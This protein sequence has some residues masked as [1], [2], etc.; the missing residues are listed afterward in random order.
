MKTIIYFTYLTTI[1]FYGA[2]SVVRDK[3]LTNKNLLD[4]A[5]KNT[6]M[7]PN[8]KEAI[9]SELGI[10]ENSIIPSSGQPEFSNVNSFTR[11]NR[12]SKNTTSNN[13]K[14][15]QN[16]PGFIYLGQF[17]THYYYLSQTMEDWN[18][19]STECTKL[20][21]YLVSIGS[22]E[23][24]SFILNKVGASIQSVHI[25]LYSRG[26][27]WKWINGDAV[28]FQRWASGEPNG[29]ATGVAHLL[30]KADPVYS[31]QGY[32]NDTAPTESHYF[33]LETEEQIP[34]QSS[35]ISG[36]NFLGQFKGHNYYLSQTMEDWNSASTECTKLG[37]YLVSI[38]SNEENSFILNKVGASIQSVHIGLYSRGGY[39]KWINGDAVAFQRWASGE[40]NGGATGVAHLLCK[41]DPVYSRQG[42]WNDTAPTES[43]YFVLET[44]E[45][46]PEQSS[47]ISGFNFLGQF[48]GHNYYLSQTMEDWNSASTECTKLGGYLVSIRSNEENSFILNKVGASIQ[49]VH[50]GLYSRGGYWKWINGDAVAFQ[51]WASGEPNGGATG[52]AH[53]LCKADPVYSR[54]GYWNDTAPTESHYFVLEKD[55]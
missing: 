12:G 15:I 19:A 34:E 27:Y 44:E 29:G 17:G 24:N 48:K 55:Y 32:W 37:G 18:S 21:G 2:F 41:A 52:V 30:C 9:A 50:I 1:L 51:R 6:G 5:I 47:D 26:G 13:S 38:G 42:Y 22:N 36:F 3:D 14:S 8:Y 33:V 31:R 11:L 10:G 20:G 53:L 40:P 4:V 7:D 45:Q 25:G 49:S 16:I 35:D 54:Q 46:I 23:E 28:A 43:H 39:W